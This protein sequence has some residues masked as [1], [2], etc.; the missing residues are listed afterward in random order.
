MLNMVAVYIA[1]NLFYDDGAKFDVLIKNLLQR[2]IVL[3]QD[4]C[5]AVCGIRVVKWHSGKA[6]LQSM[7]KLIQLQFL[8][9]GLSC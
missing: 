2:S 8:N 4:C 7:S 9:C 5:H 1:D 6:K 3:R